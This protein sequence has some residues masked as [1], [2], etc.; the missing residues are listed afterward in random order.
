MLVLTSRHV[1]FI[2]K[3]DTLLAESRIIHLRPSEVNRSIVTLEA[4]SLDR[5][6]ID[7]KFADCRVASGPGGV[8]GKVMEDI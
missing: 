2:N 8:L 3:Q 1:L 5:D 4:S 7:V 6:G